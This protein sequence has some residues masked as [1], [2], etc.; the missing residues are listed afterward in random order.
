MILKKTLITVGAFTILTFGGF[1]LPTDTGQ[2]EPSSLSEVK[3]E[4]KELKTK[5][6]KKE[7]EIV[8]VLEEIE[9]LHTEIEEL[10]NT[11][12]N[13]N[14]AIKET[15]DQIKKHEK[16]IDE[17][18]KDIDVIND[19]I[20]ERAEI[21]KTRLSSYQENGNINFL[22]VVLGSKGFMDFISRIEAVTTITNADTELIEQQ[23]ADREEVEK[24]QEEVQVKLDEQEDAKL[25]LEEV[26]K[27]TEEQKE[28]VVKSKKK[29]DTQK[30]KLESEKSKL[31]SK[32]SS[33]AD[34]EAQFA[35]T[36][37]SGNDN[38]SS[39]NS[40]TSTAAATSD[41]KSSKAPETEVNTAPPSGGVIGN[42]MSR[43]GKNNTYVWGGKNPQ[44]GFDCSGF[45]S[46]AYG[47]KVPSST[48]A[49]QSVGTQVEYKDAQPGD[50]IF[51]DTYKK[52]GHVAIYIGNGQFVG[53]QSSTGV[54]VA[55]VNDPHY[56]GP[57][58]KG[59]V[60]RVN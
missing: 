52:N 57:K 37:S 23:E 56:W 53:S 13:N 26:Q 3:Q 42:A 27:V 24:L 19:R 29:F 46:W 5:L 16:K 43:V 22:D 30:E 14:K 9:A 41:E 8:S 6:S 47:N 40:N 39:N 15:N 48:S 4:R 55:N 34:L 44:Q 35:P 58:F 25:D 20:E 28:K 54:A 51:F 17:I 7:K 60:R 11:I 10:E 50:L 33:L 36:Y 18:Q 32:D 31:T 49:L 12:D 38:S 45:V 2:A 21:L 1:A 59:H